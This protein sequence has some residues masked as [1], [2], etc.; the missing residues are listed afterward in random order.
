[1][2][3]D[4]GRR[5]RHVVASAAAAAVVFIVAGCSDRAPPL[6]SGPPA[7][8]ETSE[9]VQRA[10]RSVETVPAVGMGGLG[11]PEFSVVKR[12]TEITQ[13]P[14]ASCHTPGH[15]SGG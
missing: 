10:L 15:F 8:L 3:G 9:A 4:A 1:M 2:R 11:S 5:S 7:D 14:C 13:D 12:T 6:R